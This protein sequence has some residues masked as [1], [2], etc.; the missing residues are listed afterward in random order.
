M[1]PKFSPFG[2]DK[3]EC[4][5]FRKCGDCWPN[6]VGGST[7]DK[8]A[9]ENSEIDSE[10]KHFEGDTKLTLNFAEV[11]ESSHWMPPETDTFEIRSQALDQKYR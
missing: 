3:N 1:H 10:K 9:G 4:H 8:R 5:R 6:S 11:L 2:T 7:W